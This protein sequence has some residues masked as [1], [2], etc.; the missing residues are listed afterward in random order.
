MRPICDGA[1]VA[2][3]TRRCRA[4]IPRHPLSPQPMSQPADTPSHVRRVVLP[5]GRAIEVAYFDTRQPLAH[6]RTST[7]ERVD[8]QV[9]PTC[10]KTLVYPIDW[11]EASP[12]HWQVELRCP[13]CEWHSFGTYGQETVDHCG[14]QLD[15]GTEALM[16]D[17]RRLTRA[18]MEDELERFG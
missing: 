4:R 1:Q 13:N 10:D 5:S 11:Q 16:A 12:T 8:L 2:V 6:A 14:E 3:Q 9:C 18:N 15:R 17:L 7:R